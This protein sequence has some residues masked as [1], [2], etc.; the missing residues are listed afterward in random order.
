LY[1]TEDSDNPF[2]SE[3]SDSQR[4]ATGLSGKI[5]KRNLTPHPMKDGFLRE[6]IADVLRKADL[7]SLT[8]QQVLGDVEQRAGY[9]LNSDEEAMLKEIV[10]NHLQSL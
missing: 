8:I 3:D 10:D 2:K 6:I 7:E 9:T 5:S 1:S 4:T